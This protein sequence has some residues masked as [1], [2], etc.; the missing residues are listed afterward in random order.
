M[1]K[2]ER[3]REREREISRFVP[4]IN[5]NASTTCSTSPIF[6]ASTVIFFA[7]IDISLFLFEA[8]LHA[9][10][11]TQQQLQPLRSRVNEFTAQL[12]IIRTKMIHGSY[13]EC[14]KGRRR[15]D[16]NT[17]TRMNLPQRFF[18]LK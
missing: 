15:M 8:P 16:A 7:S 13:S 2:T 17:R 18:A 4:A 1:R 11:G 9:T 14:N 3:E 10:S 6:P 12:A 5:N